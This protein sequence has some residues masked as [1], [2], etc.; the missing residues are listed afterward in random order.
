MR[1]TAPRAREAGSAGSYTMSRRGV[2]LVESGSS[3]RQFGI[4]GFQGSVRHISLPLPVQKKRIKLDLVILC[5]IFPV[6]NVY[7][8]LLK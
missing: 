8:I 2:P 5:Q 3:V 1:P 7:S 4:T 6:N